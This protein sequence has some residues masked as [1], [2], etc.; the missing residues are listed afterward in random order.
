MSKKTLKFSVNQ[1]IIDGQIF[2]ASA[3]ASVKD[4]EL[5]TQVITQKEQ[6]SAEVLT[7]KKIKKAVTENRFIA[8]YFNEGDKFP[9]PKTVIDSTDPNFGEKDNPRPPEQIELDN[10]FFVL[11]DI[12]KQR[13]FM[14]DGR[15]K[16]SFNTWLL[17][18]LIKK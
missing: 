12:E 2:D 4:E 8:I 6:E 5:E 14:S 13:V 11:A 18:K 16:G 17:K 7:I 15:K 10:Q 3:F 1:L 9:Y